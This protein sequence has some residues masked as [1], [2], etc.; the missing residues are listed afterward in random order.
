[1]RDYVLEVTSLMI[2]STS[3]S[4]SVDLLRVCRPSEWLSPTEKERH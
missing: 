4:L 1:M 3:I 2:I